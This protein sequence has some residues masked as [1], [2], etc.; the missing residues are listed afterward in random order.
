MNRETYI[1]PDVH[2]ATISLAVRDS[3]GEVVMESI[4][5]TKLDHSR[6]LGGLRGFLP[7]GH[8]YN[9][10]AQNPLVPIPSVSNITVRSGGTKSVSYPVPGVELVWLQFEVVKAK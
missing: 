7:S 4:L 8:L 6:V 2:Q 10:T 9:E 3:K 5:K 1:G